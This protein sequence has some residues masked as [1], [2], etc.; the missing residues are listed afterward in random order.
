MGARNPQNIGAV[1]RAM[2]NFGFMQLRIVNEYAVPLEAARSAVN[3]GHVLAAAES[4]AS[5][6][7]AVADCRL[8]VGTTAAGERR[9]EHELV[10]LDAAGARVCAAAE[11]G[12]VALLFGSEKTGLTNETLAQCNWLMTVPM[13]AAGTSMNLGQAVAVCL[14]ELVR[15]E[16]LDAAA[17]MGDSPGAALAAEVERL[18]TVLREAL[19]VSGYHAANMDEDKMRRLVRRLALRSRDAEALTG[20][21]RQVLWKLRRNEAAPR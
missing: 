12:G 9:L 14:W 18:T 11:H 20:M 17:V 2:S 21:L 16:A 10:A 7:E 3:A 8:V 6:A 1:A 5:V 4:F 15:G 13:H 19:A